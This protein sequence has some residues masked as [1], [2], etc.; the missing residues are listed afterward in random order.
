MTR[1]W[2]LRVNREQV[3]QEC[4]EMTDAHQRG[5]VVFD[6]SLQR[7]VSGKDGSINHLLSVKVKLSNILLLAEF[8][9]NI[10]LK[11]FDHCFSRAACFYEVVVHVL[12][13]A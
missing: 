7:L 1:R 4:Q 9:L 12:Q 5:A 6:L 11:G 2:V 8:V 3:L 13:H 10:Y